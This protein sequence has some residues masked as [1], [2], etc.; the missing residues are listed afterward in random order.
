MYKIKLNDLNLNQIM[1]SGQCFRMKIKTDQKSET[2]QKTETP[3]KSIYTITAANHYVEIT[4][5]E[6]HFTFSCRRDEFETIWHP[7]LDLQTDYGKIKAGIDKK[8]EYLLRAVEY[9]WGIRILRQDLWE[10][11]ITF[12]ISQNNN[13]SRIRNSVE[14]LSSQLGKRC[15]TD[16][17]GVYNAFPRPEEILEAGMERLGN[18]GLGYRDK[19]IL[20][21]AESVVK[22]DLNLDAL[23]AAGYEDAHQML[24]AQYG[25][26]KKVADCICLFGLHHVDAFPV[27]TH[28]KKILNRFY[29]GGFPYENYRGVLGIIQQYM[30]YYDLEGKM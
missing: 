16:S 1:N 9:G 6:D 26:G 28:I 7:Y 18:M 5:N 2:D 13:V 24:T 27:D 20:K 14:I 25:I 21:M 23:K 17:G 22:G 15:S 29:P 3:V 12:L 30:F 10:M 8:D 11:I 19:Y 4:Q